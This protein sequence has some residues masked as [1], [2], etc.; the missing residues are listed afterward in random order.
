M[1]RMPAT[2]FVLAMAL[3]ATAHAETYGLAA[4]TKAPD[5]DTKDLS[6]NGLKLGEL[7]QKGPVVLVLYRGGW[8]P[9]CNIQLKSLEREVVPEL[10]KATGTLVAIS[11]D[12]PD[13]GTAT[14]KENGL[15]FRIVSDPNA[16][17]L[18]K[19]KAKFVVPEELVKKYKD[20]YKIDVEG[21][22]GEKH[23]IIAVPSTYVIDAKG[24]I[25][26]AHVDENYKVRAPNAD[27]IA[28][29]KKA[30]SS[31]PKM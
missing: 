30:A 31:T 10:A 20:E 5:F 23:H 12:R 6:G 28:A 18:A 3:G 27:V 17:I 2:I 24:T 14:Q 25:V 26:Y 21:A 15:T 9:F 1:L 8:C 29:V 16:E 4:G 13:N 11:V 19:Y 22:S 7:Q